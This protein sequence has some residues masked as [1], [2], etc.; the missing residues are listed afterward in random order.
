MIDR[1]I[2][3]QEERLQNSTF[4]KAA[5]GKSQMMFQSIDDVQL[6]THDP[7]YEDEGEPTT[8]RATSALE[9]Q[10]KHQI[11]RLTR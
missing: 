2:I 5:Q 8:D 7:F 11:N 6:Q 3:D 9:Q 1:R 4:R 10:P